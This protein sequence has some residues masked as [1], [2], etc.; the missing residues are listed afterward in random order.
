MERIPVLGR[1][2]PD[3]SINETK[4]VI[5]AKSRQ[6]CPKGMITPCLTLHGEMV[7]IQLGRI[8][9]LVQ[10]EP[11][12]VSDGS[13]M[14]QRWLDHMNEWTEKKMPNGISAIVLHRPRMLYEEAV[15]VIY[16]KDFGRFKSLWN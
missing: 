2:G 8:K 12:P 3:I 14:V 15:L 13:I 16:Q 10:Y 6:E 5:D 1:T 9:E 7:A 11:Q 4:L